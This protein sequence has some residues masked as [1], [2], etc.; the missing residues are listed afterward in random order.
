MAFA[1]VDNDCLW[2]SHLLGKFFRALGNSMTLFIAVINTYPLSETN[3]CMQVKTFELTAFFVTK[4]VSVKK[5]ELIILYR[6]MQSLVPKFL[7][8]FKFSYCLLCWVVV[9]MVLLAVLFSILQ[10]FSI[11]SGETHF[12]FSA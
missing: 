1:E 2:Y 5:Q 4:K 11:S 9:R 6:N 3:I 10:I 7:D 8:S 12:R